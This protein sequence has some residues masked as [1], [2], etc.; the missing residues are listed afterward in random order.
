MNS[1]HAI[2]ICHIVQAKQ[3]VL[4]IMWTTEINYL[5]SDPLRTPG[6]IPGFLVGSGLIICLVY[7][8]VFV[9]VLF[10]FV[11]LF[12]VLLCFFFVFVLCLLYRCR[13]L[14][15]SLGCVHFYLSL[16]FSLKFIWINITS[17]GYKKQTCKTEA[18]IQTSSK[19]SSKCYIET[20]ERKNTK[21]IN[22][23]NGICKYFLYCLSYKNTDLPFF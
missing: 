6:F 17:Y 15:V 20:A 11:C 8:L 2:I 5:T 10:C 9:F 12:F 13:M 23:E 18:H 19:H 3:A 21:I 1:I 16:L 22:S 7:C 14:P 4:Y